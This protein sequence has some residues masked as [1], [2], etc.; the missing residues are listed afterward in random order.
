MFEYF[1]QGEGREKQNQPNIPWKK[2]I[3]G[4]FLLII[5]FLL[6]FLLAIKLE[7]TWFDVLGYGSVFWRSL[8]AKLMIGGSIFAAAVILNLISLYVVFRLAKKPFKLLIALAVAI[9]TATIVAGNSAELWLAILRTLHAVPFGVSDPQFQLDIGF[10]VF[11]LPFLW[12]VYRFVNIWLIINLITAAVFY[13]LLL[14]RGMEL[15]ARNVTKRILSGTEKRGIIHV[16][17]LLG[18]TI[19]WQAFR[20]KLSTYELLYSQTGS[21]VGAGAADIGARLPSYYIMMILSLV[22]G[23]MIMVLFLKRIR[24]ALLSAGGFVV[25]A[26]LVTGI[27]PGLYQKFI[28][29]PDELGK[30][31]PYLERSI[32]YTRLA[33]GLDKLTEVEYQVGDLTARDLAENRDIVDN[34]RLLDHRATMNTYSQQQEIRLYYDFVDVDT[35]R[36]LI[37]G[38]LT[39]VLLSGRELNQQSLPEQARTF[40]NLLFKYTHGFG[41]AMSPA[42]DVTETG[43]PQYLVKDIPPISTELKISEPRI[44]FGEATRNNVIVNTGLMEFDYPVGENNQEYLYQGKKG[45]PMTFLN[46]L[47]LTIR[48]MQ[49]KYLLSDYITPESQYLETRNIT[50]RAKRIAPFL[51]YDRDPYLVVGEDGKLYYFL[52]AYTYTNQYPYSQTYDETSDVNYLRNS[53]KTVVD[54]YTGEINFYIFDPKDPVI[55]VYNSIFPGLFRPGESMPMDLREHVRY[56]EDLFTVQSLILRDYHMS[57]STVFYNREDRWEF[58]QE[59]YAGERITQIPYFSIIRL[60]GDNQPEFVLMRAFTPAGKQN[61]VAWLAGRSDLDNYGK[62][63]LYKF[64]KGLQVP[65]TI[66]VES[67]I[68]QDPYISSQLTLWGQGGSRVLRGN[69]LVYPI[70]GSLL[71]V[72]PLYIEAQQN[73]FPQL[74]KVFV[75]YKDK[76]VME[77]TLEKALTAIFGGAEKPPALP[78]QEGEA[79]QPLPEDIQGLIRHLV[80]LHQEGKERLKAGDWAGYG[81]T[82]QEIDQLI[83]KLEEINP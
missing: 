19:A 4:F 25:I 48:D 46:K 29:D 54:A 57:N 33:Y 31:K 32:E 38:K 21:V 35:D 56:P 67:L 27:Y 3:L 76:I 59:T 14:P 65:G 36:Y 37:N 16:G 73:K 7:W 23:V 82:Q 20:Y 1:E 28:V 8:T 40:N 58:A 55:Q 42:N 18:L 47:L 78:G 24:L 60:P 53:V 72:E 6:R 26:V 70:G 52:D 50:D 71:Y 22:L 34:M 61:M 13:L 45:I 77:D 68:D 69:L 15:S 10:Y 63:L 83:K 81:Q 75:F 2:L 80:A 44:Y 74:K 41:L 30:E 5:L 9:F 12:L 51:M 62:L 11:R 66:Q 79:I 43:L 64:P 39:Q 49:F 17:I